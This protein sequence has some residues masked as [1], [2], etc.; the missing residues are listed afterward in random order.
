MLC[1]VIG[2]FAVNIHIGDDYD[3]TN[4][5]LVSVTRGKDHSVEYN[6]VDT[7]PSSSQDSFG[8]GDEIDVDDAT[9]VSSPVD[10]AVIEAETEIK[11]ESESDN[12]VTDV[13][14]LSTE[15]GE[16]PVDNEPKEENKTKK[17]SKSWW[18]SVTEWFDESTNEHP[19][20]LPGGGRDWLVNA[21]EGTISPKHDPSFYLGYGPARL[22]LVEKD[23]KNK[24]FFCK[25]KENESD[26]EEW[27]KMMIYRGDSNDSA[28]FV[29][30][31]PNSDSIVP[32]KGARYYDT[33]ATEWAE[34]FVVK[35]VDSNFIATKDDFVLDV[36]YW[37]I[38]KGSPVNFA[39]M[40]DGSSYTS[41]GGRDWTWN[42]DATISP[43]LNPDLVI[44]FA[45]AGLVITDMKDQAIHLK[46]IQKL[47]DGDTIPMELV[48][49]DPLQVVSM[50]EEAMYD[51][52]RYCTS[53]LVRKDDN[54]TKSPANIKYDGNYLLTS[55][56]KYALDI[57]F[58]KMETW[59]SVN[60]VGGDDGA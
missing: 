49:D 32:F 26:D 53:I 36:A 11:T 24:A 23:S 34:P 20:K 25:E 9:T 2:N 13:E 35:Y 45:D 46:Q 28:R 14:V 44:G 38:V 12:E 57:S 43:T 21:K 18:D 54:E 31:I 55:D 52:W 41:G 19:T 29:G 56:E 3:F 48:G 30:K 37:N 22:E 10:A 58:W 4:L 33:I 7:V 40:D 8:S 17:K 6:G 50:S 27:I 59:N 1:N 15:Q 16:V 47:A 51:E 5:L 42:D 39:S 60:F